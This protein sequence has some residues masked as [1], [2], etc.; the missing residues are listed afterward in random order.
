MFN[1]RN[2]TDEY[3]LIYANIGNENVKLFFLQQH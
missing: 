2:S 3:L 1:L